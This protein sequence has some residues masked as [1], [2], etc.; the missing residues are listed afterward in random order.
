MAERRRGEA[1][2]VVCNE[3]SRR[4]MKERVVVGRWREKSI[5]GPKGRQEIYHCFVMLCYV[6]L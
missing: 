4:V 6:S 2:G 1:D 3:K 5:E